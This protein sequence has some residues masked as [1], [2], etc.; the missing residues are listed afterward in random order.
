MRRLAQLSVRRLALTLL[1]L[2]VIGMLSACGDDE[3]SHPTTSTIVDPARPFPDVMV[4]DPAAE[5]AAAL[6]AIMVEV[7]KSIAEIDV[8]PSDEIDPGQ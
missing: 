8:V 5:S 4:V 7:E 1:A 6:E 3:T 2:G